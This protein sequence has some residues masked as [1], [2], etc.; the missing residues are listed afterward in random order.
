MN[1]APA[2]NQIEMTENEIEML[3]SGKF[4]QASAA[5]LIWKFQPWEMDRTIKG[6]I[7]A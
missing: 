5:C 4:T 2:I 3:F 6:E 1:K 7:A